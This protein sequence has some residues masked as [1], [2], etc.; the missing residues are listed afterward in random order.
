MEFASYIYTFIDYRRGRLHKYITP[1]GRTED[2][3]VYFVNSV[4]ADRWARD[5]TEEN[6]GVEVLERGDDYVKIEV[7]EAGPQEMSDCIRGFCQED[8]AL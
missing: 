8:T 7:F 3:N 4:K 6:I 1:D 2:T 5:T